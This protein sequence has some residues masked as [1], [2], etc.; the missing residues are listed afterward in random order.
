MTLPEGPPTHIGALLSEPKEKLLPGVHLLP[1]I[2]FVESAKNTIPEAINIPASIP[3]QQ[4]PFGTIN[5]ETIIIPPSKTSLTITKTTAKKWGIPLAIGLGAIIL[6]IGG[7]YLFTQLTST[8][9]S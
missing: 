4:I 2:E 5:S 1:M 9:A 3:A 7:G 6:L 8:R